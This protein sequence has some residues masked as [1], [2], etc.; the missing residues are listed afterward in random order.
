M[1]PELIPSDEEYAS[2]EDSDFAP[3]AAPTREDVDSSDSESEAEEP[4]VKAKQ[5]SK[6]VK[7]KRTGDGEEAED[8]GFE[9]S[10][11]EAIIE[12]GLQRQKKKGKKEGAEDDDDGGE[13]S[14]VKTRSMRA[15]EYVVPISI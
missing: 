7:R 3:D 13:G 10:G 15:Q 11:D 4:S 5:K 2:E 14:L 8:A 9:N 12:R 6:P 1:P